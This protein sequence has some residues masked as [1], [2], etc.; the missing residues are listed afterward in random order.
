MTSFPAAPDVN[1]QTEEDHITP[2]KACAGKEAIR[3]TAASAS[4]ERAEGHVCQTLVL[5][6]KSLIDALSPLQTK[7]LA[8]CSRPWPEDLCCCCFTKAASLIYAG[9]V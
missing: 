5:T 1:E 2:R 8:V 4:G 3:E 7:R 6:A 9:P